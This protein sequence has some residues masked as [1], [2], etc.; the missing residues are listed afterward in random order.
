[1][2]SHRTQIINSVSLAL[3]FPF[4]AIFLF[5]SVAG[6]K[7]NAHTS[8]PKLRQID[9]MLNSQLPEGTPKS[10]VNFYLSSQG[11]TTEASSDD[12]TM[13]AIV[14]HVDTETLQPAAAR[15]TFH[16]DAFDKLKSYDLNPA[17]GALP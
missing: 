5:L 10:R 7:Q 4:L 14:R 13:V 2:N 12:H 11:F 8:D 3:R 17:T 9:E 6:C 15:V 16:F 1:M